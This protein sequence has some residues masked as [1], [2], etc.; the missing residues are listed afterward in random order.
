MCFLLLN[1]LHYPNRD[2]W[3]SHS[4]PV[5]EMRQFWC[6][7]Q[8]QQWNVSESEPKPKPEETTKPSFNLWDRSI[9]TE[10]K[11]VWMVCSG[12]VNCGMLAELSKPQDFWATLS[13]GNEI[14]FYKGWVCPL[15]Y[16]MKSSNKSIFAQ[17]FLAM[18]LKGFRFMASTMG[19]G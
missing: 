18:P 1:S 13:T 10:L 8:E 9:S 7:L 11:K 5:E 15:A 2:C 12:F 16:T 19:V 17:E 4:G 6:L 14:I 3:Q